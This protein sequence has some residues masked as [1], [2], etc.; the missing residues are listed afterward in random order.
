MQKTLILAALLI[1]NLQAQ[2]LKQS[3]EEILR[4]NPQILEK[5]SNY[6][7]EREDITAA[8]SGYYPKLDLRV[9]AGV[10]DVDETSDPNPEQN[11]DGDLYTGYIKLSQNLFE[12]FATSSQIDESKAKTLAA[13][14]KYVEVADDI[15]LRMVNTYIEVMRNSELLGTAQKNVDINTEIFEKVKKLYDAGLTTLSE[16]N[17]IESSLALAKS[18][19]VV[20]ENNLVDAEYNLQRVLGKPLKADKMIRPV[21]TDAS[22]PASAEAAKEV[23]MKKNPSLLVSMYNIRQ[24]RASHANSRSNYYPRL[25]L[26]VTESYDESPNIAGSHEEQD[27]RVM[28][29]L[30]YNLFNGFA[31]ESAIQKNVSRVHQEIQT[32]HDLERQVLEG[33]NLSWASYTKLRD[34]LKHLEDYKLYSEKT[35]KLYVKEY[36]LGRRSLLDLLAAQND[37]IG[38][39]SQIITTEY[40]ILLAKH[41]ILDAMGT[42]IPTILEDERSV[43]ANVGINADAPAD[44]NMPPRTKTTSE[45]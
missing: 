4:T 40:S 44:D 15:S 6:K 27:F 18:N 11:Y 17:K 3:I 13:S 38:S 25:D 12:G 42:L 34:Q 5:Q 37:F 32:R 35:L 31:D 16:V 19:Y 10:S 20:Q 2:T 7:A 45:R 14:Y 29:Y 41:R 33:L 8:Q 28:V 30:T 36:D 22:L 43:Y 21:L 1:I 24:A 39:Q 9:G 26:E 23:A